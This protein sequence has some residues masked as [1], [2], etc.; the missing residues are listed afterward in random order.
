MGEPIQIEKRSRSAGIDAA[1]VIAA[2]G[3]VFTHWL[4]AWDAQSLKQASRFAVPF[5]IA[6]A[7]LFSVNQCFSGRSLS[8]MIGVRAWRI[9]LPYITW[10]A[11]YFF[12]AY[13]VS[14]W[15]LGGVRPRFSLSDAIDGFGGHLWFLPFIFLVGS[16]V[17]VL[18]RLAAKSAAM[19][20]AFALGA[21]FVAGLTMRAFPAS[22]NN[23]DRWPYELPIALVMFALA[24][25]MQRR[26]IAIPKNTALAVGLLALASMLVLWTLNF[27]PFPDR[28]GCQL[29][30][31]ALLLAGVAMP[32]QRI[33]AWLSALGRLGFGVYIT[34]S[35]LVMALHR[36]IGSFGQLSLTSGLLLYPLV[37]VGAFALTALCYKLPIVRLMMPA[38]S[39]QPGPARA[40]ARRDSRQLRVH[41]KPTRSRVRVIDH[42]KATPAPQ[43]VENAA[44]AAD[45]V[46]RLQS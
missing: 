46:A 14:G 27:E 25:A 38:Q 31:L 15:I 21:C 1:R 9:L 7:V 19:S 24:V 26:W 28:R 39:N 35:L 40:R 16:V 45:K 42:Q 37:L 30:G 2:A 23:L 18:A 34:H 4:T 22:T 33:P 17:V 36:V 13:I 41:T 44:P 43:G 32:S 12:A 6:A 3:V 11:V 29:A 20:A 5:F 10:S 8:R